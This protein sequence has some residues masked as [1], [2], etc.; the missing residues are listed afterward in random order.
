MGG[1]ER[2]EKKEM[3]VLNSWGVCFLL[4]IKGGT[5]SLKQ[6]SVATAMNISFS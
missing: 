1:M 3:E 4:T 5:G 6:E 2:R